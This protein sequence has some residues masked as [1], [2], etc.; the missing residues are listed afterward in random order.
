MLGQPEQLEA[1]ILERPRQLGR[2]NRIV[3]HEHGDADVHGSA[4]PLDGPRWRVGQ[5]GAD[6]TGVRATPM[7]GWPSGA[8]APP[9]SSIGLGLLLA[10]GQRVVPGADRGREG[11]GR[12]GIALLLLHLALSPQLLL[13][14]EP[15]NSNSVMPPPHLAL[16]RQTAGVRPA[17]EEPTSD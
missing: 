17:T 6:V 13:E 11:P 1:A 5:A 15:G 7:I 14:P 9:S 3:R 4:P 2:R 8:A 10:R 16:S 12:V